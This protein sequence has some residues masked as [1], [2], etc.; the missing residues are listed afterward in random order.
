MNKD[1]IERSIYKY[2]S[3]NNNEITLKFNTHFLGNTKF[4]KNIQ[5]PNNNIFD[6]SKLDMLN[7]KEDQSIEENKVVIYGTNGQIK[8]NELSCNSINIGNTTISL[9]EIS[10]NVGQFLSINNNGNFVWTEPDKA[11]INSLNGLIDV[12]VEESEIIFGTKD[13]LS[14]KPF[15]SNKVDLGNSIRPFKDIYVRRIMACDI[16][17]TSFLG[18]SAI[19]FC[20]THDLATF[21]HFDNNN[22]NSFSIAQTSFGNTIINAKLNT[23]IDFNIDNKL[24]MQ[25]NDSG[26]FMIGTNNKEARLNIGG[27]NNISLSLDSNLLIKESIYFHND[28]RNKKNISDLNNTRSLEL[29]RNIQTIKYTNIE[30]N[31]TEYGIHF[32]L[33]NQDIKN[34]NIKLKNFIPNIC[35]I[36]KFEIIGND[37]ILIFNTKNTNDLIKNNSTLQIKKNDG[38]VIIVQIMSIIDSKRI[39]INKDLTQDTD[40]LYNHNKEKIENIHGISTV[41]N[42]YIFVY[43][44]EVDDFNFYK[45]SSIISLNTSAI[46]ELDKTFDKNI[47]NINQEL[48]L[49]QTKNQALDEKNQILETKLL[50]LE[51][52]FQSNERANKL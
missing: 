46:K 13:I 22:N 43:G 25:L 35:E 6:S 45:E 49:L 24:K 14:W 33:S 44:Q 26:N 18:R 32:D 9:P 2:M 34:I 19:G 17:I 39:I 30:T 12:S 27:Y 48:L 50:K 40:Y 4:S 47:S 11:G 7:K 31:N 1:Y 5:L 23:T 41:F 20:G 52:I 28:N 42:N 36:C 29:I 21:S 16:D 3:F 15:L 38:T 8:T 37:N 10:P 51:K